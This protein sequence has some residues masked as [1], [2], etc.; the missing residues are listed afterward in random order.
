MLKIYFGDMQNVIYNTSVYFKYSYDVTWFDDP[1]VKKM[2]EDV[3]NSRVLGGSAI[4]S[5]VLGIIPPTSLSGGVKCLILIYK[6]TE[7]VFNASN[8]GDNCAKWLLEIGKERD[9]LVNLR[10][11]MEFEGEFEIYIENTGE[12]VHNMEELVRKAGEFV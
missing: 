3:D 2:I 5:P 6:N 1:F 9:V 10:H 7:H 12:I 8:C 4:D 11:L